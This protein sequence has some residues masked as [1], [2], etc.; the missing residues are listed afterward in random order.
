[1]GKSQHAA[2]KAARYA[3]TGDGDG[4]GQEFR[5]FSDG[6]VGEFVPDSSSGCCLAAW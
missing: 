2:A 4:E 1:M 5:A 3:G 6:M